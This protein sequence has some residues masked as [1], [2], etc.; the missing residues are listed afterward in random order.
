MRGSQNRSRVTI[1]QERL[2]SWT[3]IGKDVE[4]VNS[5]LATAI[6]QSLSS[7]TQRPMFLLL[8]YPYGA[9]IVSN[10]KFCLPPGVGQLRDF[11][12]NFAPAGVPLA[13]VL[14]K[15]VEIYTAGRNGLTHAMRVLYPGELFGAFEAADW[16]F[17]RTEPSVSTYSVSSGLRSVWIVAPLRRLK[18]A[19]GLNQIETSFGMVRSLLSSGESQDWTCRILCLPVSVFRTNGPLRDY[20]LR[21]AWIQSTVHRQQFGLDERIVQLGPKLEGKSY[22]TEFY[23]FAYVEVIKH[24]ASIVRG[25]AAAYRAWDEPPDIGGP[26]EKVKQE[27]SKRA[28]KEKIRNF[29]TPHILRPVQLRRAGDY[30]F[31]SFSEDVPGL[32]LGVRLPEYGAR[33]AA[34]VGKAFA[35]RHGGAR[36]PSEVNLFRELELRGR[37]TF[38]CRGRFA[39]TATDSRSGPPFSDAKPL[40]EREFLRPEQSASTRGLTERD[41]GRTGTTGEEAP[42]EIWRGDKFLLACVR[43]ERT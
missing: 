32:P 35:K 38:F 31:Y 33:Q 41:E 37:L 13:V 9:D 27:I 25:L 39:G 29:P 22:K 20:V 2:I 11:A 10:N 15:A 8:T 24:I 43:I 21:T 36:P 14:D 4:K 28:E 19:L 3:D 30:G 12:K 34:E 26:F 7:Q 16:L 17:D 5:D 42:R 18:R 1:M 23:W 6:T 40:T